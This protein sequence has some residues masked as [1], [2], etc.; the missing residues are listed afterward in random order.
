MVEYDVR[1]L[2]T[3]A[4]ELHRAIPNSL[5]PRDCI[6]IAIAIAQRYNA[7]KIKY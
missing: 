6:S 7:L 5:L 2:V 4:I 1:T 3:R